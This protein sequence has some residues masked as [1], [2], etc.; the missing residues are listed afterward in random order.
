MLQDVLDVLG[1]DV[2]AVR[3]DDHVLRA[4]AQRQEAVG[5]E[6]AEIAGVV[7]AVDQAGTGRLFVLPV[8]GED[9]RAAHEDLAVLRDPDLDTRQRHADGRHVLL[10]EPIEGHA[11]RALG[12][13]VPLE[14][15]DAHVLPAVAEGGIERRPA[16]DDVTELTAELAVYGREQ[17]AA[18][19]H[20]QLL[21]PDVELLE[22]LALPA[23]IDLAFD[24]VVEEAQRL[25][26]QE[27]HRHAEIAERPEDDRRLPARRVCDRRAR[28]ERR[29][30]PSHLFEHVREGEQREHPLFRAEREH[31][32]R[33]FRVR[34]D[35]PVREHRA[36]RVAGGPR[37][38]DDLHEIVARDVGHRERHTSARA[39][40]KLLD[41][42][43]RQAE[44]PRL[45]LGLLRRDD[46]GRTR[47]LHD[48]R[49]EIRER[50][51]VERHEDRASLERT[52]ER[53]APLRTVHRPDD[54]AIALRDAG[55]VEDARHARH[56]V[57][58]LPVAPDPRAKAGLDE[59]RGLPAE[60]RGR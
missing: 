14:D 41:E 30:E 23:G 48:L 43:D 2:R 8:A 10:V 1:V 24:R 49:R 5:V 28:E 11:R 44:L 4:A 26:H 31:L 50:A 60:P 32:E 7:P 58:E 21:R 45:G 59:E 22:D 55:V 51:R 29:R 13:P 40:G 39:V 33:S 37:G 27:H 15:V 46:R 12:R 6:L 9:V 35:V 19:P 42:V 16:R 17:D 34:E 36:L 52:E 57:R 25:R 47:P 56:D 18:Q 3:E 38:E 20:R 53:D 54:D